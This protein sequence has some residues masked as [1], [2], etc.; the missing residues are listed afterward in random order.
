MPLPDFP[1]EYYDP[2]TDAIDPGA[3]VWIEDHIRE[4]LA[5]LIP[6]YQDTPRWQA[7]IASFLAAVQE[8]ET[9][10]FDLWEIPLS[11]EQATAE[12]LNLIGRIVRED[13]NGRSDDLYRLALRVRV[14][15]NRSQGRI[16]ELIRIVELFEDLASEADS[17]V[18]VQDVPNARIEVRIVRTPVNEPSEVQKRLRQAKAA[19]VALRTLFHFGGPAA[20]FRFSRAADYPEESESEGFTNVPADVAGGALAHVRA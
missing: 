14:L 6:E 7:W 11:I 9:A 13:R 5:L 2:P 18:K 20:S 10:A 15:V 12:Q 16:E 1:I 8:L 19:G 3:V 4:G 17:Y